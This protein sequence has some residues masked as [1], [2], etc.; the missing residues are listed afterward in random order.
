MDNHTRKLTGLTDKNITF[1]ENWFV[2][3]KI[4]G[5]TI[6][7]IQ[8]KLSY[9]PTH[10]RK[11][12]CKN[13]GTIVKN[14]THL[15][16]SQLV[17]IR[18][19]KT[20]LYLKR[21]RFLCRKCGATFNAQTSL[22]DENHHLSKEL[23]YK[24]ALELK[25]NRS[26]KEIAED[27]FVSDVTV[28]RVLR[29]FAKEYKPNFKYLPSVLCI[30]EFRSL[31]ASDSPMSFIFMN[32]HTNQIIEILESRRFTFLKT[33]F[34]RYSRKAR[35]KVKYLVMDMNAPYA[36]LIKSVFPNAQV[37]TDRFHIVQHINRTLNQYRTQIMNQFGK[38]KSKD[39]KRIY[40]HLKRFWRL[41]LKDS[42]EL[43][44]SDYYY[45]RSFKRPMSQKSIIDEL[46]SYSEELKLAYE[47][48][49]MLLY[50]YRKKHST[51]FFEELEQLDNR[52]PEWFRKKL[53]FFKKYKQGVT[54]AF[55]LTYSNG[56]V[57]G[58]N[59][60]IKVIKRVAYG[61]RNFINFRSRIYFIQGLILGTP[62][63]NTK[64]QTT[65]KAA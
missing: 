13:E 40:R 51:A 19:R 50:H 57:E 9:T 10:C 18:G 47:T 16:R 21:S 17:P 54:N 3:K 56:M 41:F 33:H 25:K 55:Q 63:S 37:V 60:K 52:L 7:I 38:G 5:Q 12:G 26:R 44:S 28:M 62:A 43:N 20:M 39:D 34:M 36:K 53:T 61:Y 14:G 8:G 4:K 32:G 65:S 42:E 64:N 23:I 46:L 30:D 49:Q 27:N 2:E 35:L 45:N 6:F 48:C 29:T 11:C 1:E 31:N 15:T 59:N 58:T 22:I 24:I